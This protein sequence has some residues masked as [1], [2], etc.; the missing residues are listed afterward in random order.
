MGALGQN[1][2]NVST[3]ITA[4]VPAPD[5]PYIYMWRRPMPFHG[6]ADSGDDNFVW[7]PWL[8]SKSNDPWTILQLC[9]SNNKAVQYLGVKALAGRAWDDFQ[10]RYV[11]QA[12]DARTLIGLARMKGSNP[13]FFLPMPTLVNKEKPLVEELAGLVLA[14]ENRSSKQKTHGS[15]ASLAQ[16]RLQH[17]HKHSEDKDRFWLSSTASLDVPPVDTPIPDETLELHFLQAIS[18]MAS[19]SEQRALFVSRHGLAALQQAVET[20]Q[21]S[22]TRQTV[23]NILGNLALDPDLH[24]AIVRTGWLG[25]LKGWVEGSDTPLAVAAGRVLANLDTEWTTDVL[26]DGV[27][28]LHPLYRSRKTVH[29]DIIFVHGLLGGAIKTWRQQDLPPSS[30]PP[31]YP[32]SQCWPKDW[33]AEDCPHVRILSLHYNTALSM[34]SGKSD[35]EKSTLEA[36]SKELLLKLHHAGVGCRPVIWVGH[37]MGGLLIKKMLQLAGQDERYGSMRENTCGLLLYSVPHHGLSLA[38]LSNQAHYLLYPST[39]VQELSRDPGV[40]EFCKLP[41]DHISICKPSD[42]D[43]ELYEK[44][45]SFVHRCIFLSYM[46]RLRQGVSDEWGRCTGARDKCV[47][48]GWHQAGSGNKIHPIMSALLRS[49]AH[50]RYGKVEV[51]AQLAVGDWIRSG[52][53]LPVDNAY[54][55]WPRSGEMDLLEAVAHDP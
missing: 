7:F 26:D 45:L 29:A 40:G 3:G 17:R 53:M 23:A 30:P 42:C 28:I 18:E 6:L 11:A 38:A 37:S 41:L 10:C 27:L 32:R 22:K 55:G 35:K 12:A 5:N 16:Y 46:N 43:S 15:P 21:D 54:G 8:Q 13:L 31:P 20:R 34:W 24:E 52:R 19:T 50:I 33:L 9:K 1:L 25:L 48:H 14:L 4:S 39:E 51:V 44:T 2:S 36:R 47:A 49:T